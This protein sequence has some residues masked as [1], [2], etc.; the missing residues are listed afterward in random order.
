MKMTPLDI[1][2][3]RFEVQMRGYSKKEVEA[4]LELTAGEFEEVVRENISLKEELK[5][6]QARLEQHLEREK[7][8]QETMVTAQ[9]ISED[10]K[11]QA[12]KEAEV[13]IAEAEL[14]ADKIV[15]GANNRLIDLVK[16]LTELKRQKV[17]F[18]SHLE[19][20]IESHRKLLDTW[21]TQ[22]GGEIAYLVNKK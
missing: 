8:L 16:E 11:A 20:L 22:P 2:Q 10:V 14:Q 9:R 4:F 5:R 17:Q 3:K 19:S 15:A 6:V 21:K 12:K 1:R 7:A 18:E 13:L